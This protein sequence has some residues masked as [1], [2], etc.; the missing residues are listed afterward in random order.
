[1]KEKVRPQEIPE[2]VELL[3]E[4]EDGGDCPFDL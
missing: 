4:I 2:P 1:V 3:Q